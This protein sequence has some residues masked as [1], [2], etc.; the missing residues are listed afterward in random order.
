MI[1]E[2]YVSMLEK[3]A[4]RRQRELP[5]NTDKILSNMENF[6]SH[7]SL[8][9]YVSSMVVDAVFEAASIYANPTFYDGLSLLVPLIEKVKEANDKMRAEY[10]PFEGNFRME[11]YTP[12][13]D[14]QF[15]E[16]A[17]W[18]ALFPERSNEL[19]AHVFSSE[20]EYGEDLQYL[21]VLRPIHGCRMGD[22]ATLP[23]LVQILNASTFIYLMASGRND[24][25]AQILAEDDDRLGEH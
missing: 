9:H 1:I 16:F 17:S 4:A 6:I 3:K 14:A 13:F 8:K 2:D 11:I 23:L 24:L 12:P 25:A 10:G 5:E 20:T 7:I 22:E 15:K 18:C 19:F 21:P